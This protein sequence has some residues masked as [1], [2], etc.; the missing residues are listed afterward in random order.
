MVYHDGYNKE[1]PGSR[2]GA[3]VAA[4]YVFSLQVYGKHSAVVYPK[5]YPRI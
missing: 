4:Q 2:D 3:R 5:L 1:P